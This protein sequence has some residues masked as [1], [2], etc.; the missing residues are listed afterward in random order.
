MQPVYG[1]TGVHPHYALVPLSPR[2]TS[3]RST[4]LRVSPEGAVLSRQGMD[5]HA[6]SVRCHPWC[7]PRALISMVREAWCALMSS[8]ARCRMLAGQY[9]RTREE[10]VSTR[11]GTTCIRPRPTSSPTTTARFFERRRRRRRGRAVQCRTHV[12]PRTMGATCSATR[13]IQHNKPSQCNS[14]RSTYPASHG[15]LSI[16]EPSMCSAPH[17]TQRIGTHGAAPALQVGP[18]DEASHGHAVRRRPPTLTSRE[19]LDRFKMGPVRTV[20]ASLCC[21]HDM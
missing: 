1:P 4:T 9:D 21:L 11:A 10:S 7:L 12:A 15:S 6:H 5:A 16:T 13:N 17:R 19:E 8:A 14:H 2:P 20:A 18:E 3:P